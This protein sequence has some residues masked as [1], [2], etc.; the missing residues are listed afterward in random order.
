MFFPVVL[1]SASVSVREF[2]LV[3]VTMCLYFRVHLFAVFL[4]RATYLDTEAASRN[5]AGKVLS[6]QRKKT[7]T[8]TKDTEGEG[9]ELY[10]EGFRV[11]G[12]FVRVLRKPK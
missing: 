8:K 5:M 9:E 1:V 11:L 6:E 4:K 7:K 3:L 2:V 12:F 10:N